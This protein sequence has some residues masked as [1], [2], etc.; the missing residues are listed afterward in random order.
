MA[1][2]GDQ[3]K[4]KKHY[5]FPP[6][7]GFTKSPQKPARLAGAYLVSLRLFAKQVSHWFSP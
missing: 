4:L 3:C 5:I 2:A 6:T 1:A 7:T